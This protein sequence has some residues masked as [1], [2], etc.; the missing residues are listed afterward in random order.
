[1]TERYLDKSVASSIAPH[2]EQ[3]RPDWDLLECHNGGI[4][5]AASYI[6]SKIDDVHYNFLEKIGVSAEE[7]FLNYNFAPPT[8]RR[9]IGILG[10]LHK[11]VLGLGHPIF[12]QLFPFIVDVGGDHLCAGHDKQ[13][14]S[15]LSEANFQLSMFCRSIFGMTYVY[16]L[17]SQD[18]VNCEKVSV[19][20]TSLTKNARKLCESGDPNWALC[21]SCRK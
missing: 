2:E 7:A 17:L 15:H 4:F 16:N 14:H 20:Q 18:I 11:R 21:F 9:D 12:Q 19:F 5:H 13:L 3:P 10:L 8:L 1:M 6:L